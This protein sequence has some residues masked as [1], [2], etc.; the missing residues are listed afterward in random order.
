LK[1]KYFLDANVLISGLVSKGNERNLLER[2]R[3][4]NL[5]IVTSDYAL[6]EVRDFL[7]E[8]DFKQEKIDEYLIYLKSI[9]EVIRI[10]RDEVR[11]YWDALDDKKDVPILAAA[12]RSR[13]ILV[14]GDKQLTEKAKKYI[15]VVNARMALEEI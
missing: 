8:S 11:R 5:R 10:S 2:G 4:E 6:Q 15:I 14:T 13:T 3:R 12:I 1:R 9:C 7:E